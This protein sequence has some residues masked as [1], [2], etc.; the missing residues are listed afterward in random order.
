MLAKNALG[1]RNLSKLCSL[2]YMEGF[3]S[4]YPRI[5]KELIEKYHEGSHRYHLLS[6]RECSA[7]HYARRHRSGQS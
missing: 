1:Y 4:K 3:Y 6:G 5:D 2:G 7:G